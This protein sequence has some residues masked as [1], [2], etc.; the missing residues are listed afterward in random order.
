M[1]N[2]LDFQSSSNDFELLDKIRVRYQMYAGDIRSL[3]GVLLGFS[4]AKKHYEMNIPEFGKY[5]TD[6]KKVNSY[7]ISWMDIVSSEARNKEYEIP[8]F[9]KYLDDFRKIKHETLGS[10]DLTWDQRDHDFKRSLSVMN[11]DYPS[12]PLKPPHKLVAVKIPGV[13]VHAFFYD[14]NNSKYYEQCL[15]DFNRLKTW[16]KECFQIDEVQWERLS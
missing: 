6:L 7:A 5:L 2:N 10:I 3:N 14:E 4:L 1:T 15:G 12:L 9:Y 16:A 13:K 11:I 8:I